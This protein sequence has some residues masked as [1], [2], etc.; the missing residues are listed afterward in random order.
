MLTGKR[1]FDGANAASVI[2]AILERPAPSVASIAPPVLD[3]VLKR[4]LAKDP[5][6]RWQSALDVKAELEWAG[7]GLEANEAA[8]AFAR[9]RIW[10]LL[11]AAIA[12]AIGLAAV[13]FV[14]FREKPAEAPLLRASIVPADNAKFD[15][16]YGPVAISPDGSRIAFISDSGG[17]HRIWVRPLESTS[18][19]PLAGTEEA[20][21]RPFWSPDGGSVGFVAAGGKLGVVDTSGRAPRILANGQAV[22]A[23]AVWMRNGTIVYGSHGNLHTVNSSGGPISDLVL[24]GAP[25]APVDS[26]VDGALPDGNHFLYLTDAGNGREDLRAGSIDARDSRFIEQLESTALY[27]KGYLLWLRGTTLVAQPFNEKTLEVTGG[28]FPIGQDF[29]SASVSASGLLAYFSGSAGL[30]LALVDRR[31]ARASDVSEAAIRVGRIQLSPDGSRLITYLRESAG[32]DLWIYDIARRIRIPSRF[33]FDGSSIDGVW[34][35]DGKTIVFMSFAPGRYA[36]YRKPADNSASKQLLYEDAAEKFPMS[37]SPDGKFLLYLGAG[38]LWILPDPLGSHGKPFVFAHEDKFAIQQGQ[39]SPD[40]HWVSYQSN[41][42]GRN[43]IYVQ[44]F[45]GPGPKFR[46]RRAAERTRDG[47]AMARRSSTSIRT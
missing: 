8:P 41:E 14:H 39:F 42:S 29:A 34:S 15:P 11:T 2:A 6:E 20:L 35:P 38:S 18:A 37:W 23:G 4:C 36:L 26:V 1:A 19:F 10:P 40:G 47:G 7:R 13:S 32:Y 16:R 17:A 3:H 5:E 27:S 30:E 12:L 22:F 31:G 9:R 24:R 45:P 33:T 43:E 21:P 44:P 25:K 28:A 46:S